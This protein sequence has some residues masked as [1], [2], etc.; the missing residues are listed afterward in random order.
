MKNRFQRGVNPG[1]LAMGN[2][3]NR[4]DI[5]DLLRGLAILLVVIRHVQL[6]IHFEATSLMMSLP[7]QIFSAIFNSGA[8]GLRIFFVVSGFI[9]TMTALN[10][11]SELTC[12]NV[13]EFYKFRFARIAPTLIALL[14]VLTALHFLGVKDYVIKSKFSYFEALFSALTFH[15]NWLEGMKGYLPGSWDVLWSLS[16]EEVF[17]IIFPFVCLAS[18]RKSVIYSV[19]VALI[20]IG[21]FYRYSLEGNK[22]WQTKAYLSCMDSIALGCLFALLSHKKVISVLVT[23]AFSI[24]GALIVVFVLMVKKDQSFDFINNVYLFKTMLSIGVGLLLIASVR[25]QLT[26]LLR[27]FL[28]P[29]IL[30]GQLSYE[31]YLTHMFVVY[32][33][34]RLYRKYDVSINDSFVWLLGIIIVSGLLGYIVERYFSK[35]MNIWVRSLGSKQAKNIAA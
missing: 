34:F 23:N 26:P 19:L 8:E 17:Y 31:V 3:A 27:T 35:P 14:V 13:K 12:I 9:I 21:P 18:K 16:V 29:L 24:V 11:Y 22:I 30:Y 32:S 20:I 1:A 28:A 10:R 33:G 7:D 4:Y 2:G 25:Q 6:R 15:L 5:I